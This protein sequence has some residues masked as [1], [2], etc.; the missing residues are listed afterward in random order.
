MNVVLLDT[1]INPTNI[2]LSSDDY[3]HKLGVSD[4]LFVIPDTIK[5]TPQHQMRIALTSASIPVSFFNI[6]SSN[7]RLDIIY[8]T[9]KQT[10]ILP[11]G[12][13]NMG[14]FLTST[15]TALKA[16]GLTDP[17]GMTWNS[18][19]NKVTFTAQTSLEIL[20]SST[21]LKLLGFERIL[22]GI[23]T[24]V[25]IGD[26]NDSLI[27][28]FDGQQFTCTLTHGDYDKGGLLSEL[29]RVIN[30]HTAIEHYIN[31]VYN[32]TTDIISLRYGQAI[33]Y[34]M[35]FDIGSRA[36]QEVVFPE[37]RY[38]PQN[39]AQ[40]MMAGVNTG[41]PG[42][43][44][45]TYNAPTK[46][47]VF[48]STEHLVLKNNANNILDF[49][50]LNAYQI[51]SSV[52]KVANNTINYTY[53]GYSYSSIV[54][55]Q[56]LYTREELMTYVS[57]QFPQRGAANPPQGPNLVVIT[58]DTVTAKYTVTAESELVLLASSGLALFGIESITNH[59]S[60][61]IFKTTG[62]HTISS[63]DNYPTPDHSVV[64]SPAQPYIIEPFPHVDDLL[65]QQT[66]KSFSILA[67][68]AGNGQRSDVLRTIGF[69]PIQFSYERYDAVFDNNTS[70]HIVGDI[71]TAF[72]AENTLTS[73]SMCDIRGYDTLHFK[74]DLFTAGHT[75]NASAL[76][77]SNNILAQIPVDAGAYQTIQY[78]PNNPHLVDIKKSVVNTFRVWIED[79]NG[80]L[81][82]FNGMKWTATLTIYFMKTRGLIQGN[83][84]SRWGNTVLGGTT[85]ASNLGSIR[86]YIEEITKDYQ[87][88]NQAMK[89]EESVLV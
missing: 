61:T 47:F 7:N 4:F 60:A 77:N 40:T 53:D 36:N 33:K 17:I 41:G 37:G 1:D 48:H 38:T 52:L 34:K 50:G 64:V 73:D 58:Y 16:V 15:D 56:G 42:V 80:T 30:A 89:I 81:V 72:R 54:I 74:T 22:H 29:R 5:A 71:P 59:S 31:P 13:Y 87:L 25:T 49:F 35:Y 43:I 14:Q 62:I 66:L 3:N 24:H 2:L 39:L 75:Y 11:F 78:R 8:E 79:G 18:A 68:E 21:C 10:V 65:V 67:A 86:Y 69:T 32:G 46:K 28:E 44:L 6:N 57:N 70:W 19:T 85:E 76:K 88:M 23:N 27:I 55:P 9:K 82:D 26:T 45:I 63:A 20:P 84:V 51:E 12:N 83:T